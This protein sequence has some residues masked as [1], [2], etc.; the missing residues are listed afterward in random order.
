MNIDT[1]IELLAMQAKLNIII[2]NQFKSATKFKTAKAAQGFK[3]PQT[4]N[5]IKSFQIKSSNH[6]TFKSIGIFSNFSLIKSSII[7]IVFI[8]IAK[9]ATTSLKSWAQ[10]VNRKI[11]K[12]IQKINVT[13][14]ARKIKIDEK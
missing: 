9:H 1:N 6:E 13:D 14:I 3:K 4:I 5:F 11:A 2:K 8:I 7:F 10:V 12:K